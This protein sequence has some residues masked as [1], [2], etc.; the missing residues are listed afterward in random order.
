MRV[1][2]KVFGE[3]KSSVG[4]LPFRASE[5]FGHFTIHRPGAYFFLSSAEG[6][7]APMIHNS[8][9]NFNDKLI[10]KAAEFWTELALDRL[11]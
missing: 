10:P 2:K 5:D 9:F 8:N 7:D 3:G 4:K 1:G 6:E 11:Q